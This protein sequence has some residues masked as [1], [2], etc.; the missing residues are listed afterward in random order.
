MYMYTIETI[1]H[2]DKLILANDT[3]FDHHDIAK[4]QK[5]RNK[6]FVLYGAENPPL[7]SFWSPCTTILDPFQHNRWRYSFT[8]HWTVSSA[9]TTLYNTVLHTWSWCT[10]LSTQSTN[11]VQHALKCRRDQTALKP[12]NYPPSFIT[13][14]HISPG[15]AG[16]STPC[17]R[18][19]H[20]GYQSQ[21]MEII[22]HIT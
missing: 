11:L 16:L 18:S 8:F 19:V 20:P 10:W 17:R 7:D 14:Y 4:I 13:T 5:K 21:L 3:G 9:C 1:E 22:H 6:C 12:T 2:Q 15:S